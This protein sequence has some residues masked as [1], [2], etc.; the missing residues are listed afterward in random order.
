MM[1]RTRH[2]KTRGKLRYRIAGGLLLLLVIGIAGLVLAVSYTAPCEAPPDADPAGPGMRAIWR[3][4]YGSPEL[5][6]LR[7]LPMPLPAEDELLV[8]VRAASVNP[9]D[10]YEVRG[11]PYLIRLGLGLGAPKSPRVGIDFAGTVEAV[12]S[13]VRRF[14]P[15]DAVFGGA[16]GAF[17]EYVTVREGGSVAA[18]PEGVSFEQ[19]AA[20]PIAAVT[21]LQAL[22]D[23]GGLQPGQRVLINGASGGV[24]TFAVQIAKALG[25]EVTGVCSTRNLALVRSLGAD[26]VIDYTREN[27]TDGAERYDLIVDMVGN[28]ST[29]ANRRVLT[30]TGALV[31]VGGPSGNWL[32]PMVGALSALALSPW[33]GQTLKPMLARLDPADLA[34]VGE[35]VRAG[36]VRP[37]IDRRYPLAEVPAALA[38]SAKGRTRG[39]IVIAD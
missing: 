20:L 13:Q 28:H 14:R 30:P 10:R 12:G 5:L 39:K 36:S 23:D 17:G 1:A 34:A 8:R 35:L 4:C 19:A 3:G 22:R 25:A 7:E 11:A 15:G 27:Y 16:R 18:I 24:G 6:Q 26:H 37:V 38:Y 2:P 9:L 31:I 21:A 32:G 33:T 29:F